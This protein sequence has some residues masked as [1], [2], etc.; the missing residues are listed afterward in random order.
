MTSLPAASRNLALPT[1]FAKLPPLRLGAGSMRPQ[2][3]VLAAQGRLARFGRIALMTWFTTI[4]A[5]RLVV[6]AG[7][8]EFGFDAR[9]YREAAAT[10]LVGLNPWS[11]SLND[12]YFAAPPPSLLVASIL[13]P[14]PAWLAGPCV[15][16]VGLAGTAWA[17]RRLRLP[18]W[19]LLFPP[20]VDGLWNGDLDVL[21]L[22]LLLL[23]GV[24]AGAGVFAKVYAAVPL[25]ILGRWR[26]L[27]VAL[28]VGVIT[29]PVLQWPA[30]L[31]DV[32]AINERLLHQSSGGM[33][34]FVWLPLVPV[35]L[36]A[37][38]VMGRRRAAWLS[39]PALWPWS[40]WYYSVLAVPGLTPLA[41]A[42]FAV[43]IQGAPVVGCLLVALQ[44]RLAGESWMAVEPAALGRRP[45]PDRLAGE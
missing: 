41:A 15:A 26:P 8:G 37:L 21:L 11:V 18:P 10:W 16:G 1:R 3:P 32:A 17:L 7:T 38:V 35:G 34:G 39:V 36:F 45:E 40:Q 29:F 44:A 43:P 19:W 20:L 31:A 6:L 25:A 27:V 5:Q 14:L 4:S 9:L 28:L 2:L 23:P 22:P 42:V 30:Y 33:S 13:V 12:T 24:A